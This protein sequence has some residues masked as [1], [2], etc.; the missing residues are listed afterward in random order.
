MGYILTLGLNFLIC[1]IK[2]LAYTWRSY[3]QMPT[4]TGQGQNK[5]ELREPDVGALTIQLLLPLAKWKC[6][7]TV[8]RYSDFHQ[9]ADIWIFCEKP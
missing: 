4:R 3:E 2:I 8:P 5:N 6:W 9:K 7:P 1:R